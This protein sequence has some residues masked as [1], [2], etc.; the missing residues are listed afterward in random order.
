M[1]TTE[2]NSRKY[3]A[4]YENSNV[5]LEGRLSSYGKILLLTKI[6]MSAPSQKLGFKEC[7]S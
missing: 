5:S 2:N 3:E 6:F 7:L 1:N 4:N